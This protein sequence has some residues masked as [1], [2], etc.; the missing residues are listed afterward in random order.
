MAGISASGNSTFSVFFAFRLALEDDVEPGRV[1]TRERE[2]EVEIALELQLG[3]IDDLEPQQVSVPVRQLSNAVVGDAIGA[4]LG[5]GQVLEQHSRHG[6]ESEAP[7]RLK[8]AVPGDNRVVAVDQ[9]RVHEAE[10]ADRAGN[11]VDLLVAMPPGI[12]GVRFE[13]S[14]RQVPD[15]VHGQVFAGRQKRFV[16]AGGVLGRT[17]GY[18][19]VCPPPEPG[20]GV[21]IEGKGVMCAR[22]AVSRSGPPVGPAG[23]E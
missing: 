15:H 17:H 8:A 4:D 22:G 3:E 5:V 18:L 20:G 2:I 1:E 14:E 6:R 13:R 11:E 12:A 19:R 10:L 9:H 21:R 23:T 16:P 7:S